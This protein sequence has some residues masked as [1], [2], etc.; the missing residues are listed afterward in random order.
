MTNVLPQDARRELWRSY[1]ARFILGGSAIALIAALIA[2]LA[3][4]PS[5]LAL[6][7]TE[8][9]ASEPFS[10]AAGDVKDREDIAKAQSLLLALSH[11]ATTSPSRTVAEALALRPAKIVVDHITYGEGS[12]V[13]AGTAGSREAINAYKNALAAETRFASVSV[14]VGDLTVSQ[15]GRFSITLTGTF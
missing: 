6:N 15:S 1:R 10:Q 3:L 8:I 12:I 11:L 9:A 4:L 7:A 5:Y 13:L 14:P 2:A